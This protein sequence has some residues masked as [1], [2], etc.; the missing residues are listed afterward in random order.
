ME[1]NTIYNLFFLSFLSSRPNLLTACLR[2]ILPV[3]IF[4]F[5]LEIFCNYI[6]GFLLTVFSSRHLV[7]S[8]NL[9][10]FHVSILNRVRHLYYFL[11]YCRNYHVWITFMSVILAMNFQVPVA[12]RIVQPNVLHYTWLF[13]KANN[14]IVGSF[15]LQRDLKWCFFWC[16]W[17]VHVVFYWFSDDFRFHKL[18][19]ID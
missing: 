8:L 4:I 17:I 6:W 13:L 5:A 10:T 3:D 16:S 11:K 1:H 2:S 19:I 14:S 12:G 7:I 15:F 9:Y 18:S